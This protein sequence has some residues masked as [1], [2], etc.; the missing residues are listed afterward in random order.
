MINWKRQRIKHAVLDPSRF[1]LQALSGMA[2]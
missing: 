2:E 1:E